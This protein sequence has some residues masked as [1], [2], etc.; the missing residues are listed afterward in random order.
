MKNP[1][2][3]PPL[4]DQLE[5]IYRELPDESPTKSFFQG[6]ASMPDADIGILLMIGAILCLATGFALQFIKGDK[7]VVFSRK[8]WEI[9]FPERSW[10]FAI[11]Y[12]FGLLMTIRETQV[13][14][15]YEYCKYL[16]AITTVGLASAIVLGLFCIPFLRL[17]IR[18]YDS[19][20]SFKEEVLL[21]LVQEYGFPQNAKE[22]V[23]LFAKTRILRLYGNM[24]T[25]ATPLITQFEKLYTHLMEIVRTMIKKVAKYRIKKM[26]T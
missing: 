16:I 20:V 12:Y 8:S 19:I 23:M 26:V 2:D 11:V 24:R 21:M 5:R 25:F 4:V 1:L 18:L 9:T 17:L 14:G 15:L 22:L 13:F 6:W 7:D 3:T 10:T